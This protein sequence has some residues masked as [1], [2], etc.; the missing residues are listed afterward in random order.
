MAEGKMVLEQGINDFQI[1]NMNFYSFIFDQ[2]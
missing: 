2:Y 1:I